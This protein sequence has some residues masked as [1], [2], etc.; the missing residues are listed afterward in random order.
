MKT[1]LVCLTALI[2]APAAAPALTP[3]LIPQ[4]VSVEMQSGAF[5][6]HS[7]VAVVAPPG[8]PEARQVAGYL[9]SA[10]A[11]PTGWQLKVSESAYPFL[12]RNAIVLG[13][14]GQSPASA[15]PEGYELVV[16]TRGVRIQSPTPAGLFYG[17]QT[18]LQL[19]P[20]EIESQTRRDAA[21]AVPCLHIVD[22]PRFAW[23][24][25]MLDVSRHFFTKE[26]VERYIDR[27]ARYKMNVFHWHL[28]D[29]NG[30]RIEIK[31]L[32]QLTQV[33]A[34]PVPRLAR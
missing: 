26:F 10:I 24:G 31:A 33:G 2:L 9:A 13:L 19:L 22:Y 12:R 8:V 29:D 17:V 28:T 3:A 18:L 21:F 1:T 5:R 27:M 7:G 20:P 16:T 4:P 32:P 11:A 30:W 34:W 15:H 23:R 6:L 14:S 25:L